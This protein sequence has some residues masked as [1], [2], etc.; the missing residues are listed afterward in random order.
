MLASI[1]P[2]RFSG[3]SIGLGPRSG[4]NRWASYPGLPRSGRGAGMIVGSAP[5]TAIFVV[6]RGFRRLDGQWNG[7]HEAVR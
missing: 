4:L 1:Y 6:I 5:V 3:G 2:T 7:S